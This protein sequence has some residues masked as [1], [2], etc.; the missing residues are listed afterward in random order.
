MET[1]DISQT[2]QPGIAVWPGDP[3]FRLDPVLRIAEDGESNV[4]ILRLG[5]HTGTHVDAPRHLD[6]SGKDTAGIPVSIFFGPARVIQIPVETCI[7]GDDLAPLSW[8]GVDRVL[9]RTRCSSHP[10]NLFDQDFVYLDEGAAEYLTEKGILLVGIDAPSV[11]PFDSRE[12]RSHRMLLQHGIVILENLRLG[13][14]PP[15]DYN[16][17]CLPL[18]LADADGSP[19]RAILWK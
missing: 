12:L 19:V 11:D 5:T 6:A 3:E 15:G 2:L 10:E 14:V 17:V 8:Q 16:L 18:K 4:S 1:F 13:H 7:R 9:F